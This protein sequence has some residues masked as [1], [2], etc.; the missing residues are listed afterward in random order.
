MIWTACADQ[1]QNTSLANNPL[2]HFPAV[3]LRAGIKAERRCSMGRKYSQQRRFVKPKTSNLN[4]NTNPPESQAHTFQSRSI[5]KMDL[6]AIALL[7]LAVLCCYANTLDSDFVHDD[8]IEI[9]QN[10]YVR[11]FSN[12]GQ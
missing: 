6:I 9:L 2:I 1:F 3:I 10:E 12:L 8:T 4:K 5:R 11:D 7:G